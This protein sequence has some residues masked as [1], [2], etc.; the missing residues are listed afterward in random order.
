MAEDAPDWI[1]PHV[2]PPYVGGAAICE[3]VSDG[4]N[5]RL[6]DLTGIHTETVIAMARGQ[7]KTQLAIEGGTLYLWFRFYTIG[8]PGEYD[9]EV[10]F[11]APS[12]RCI[13]RGS[14]RCP[15]NDDGYMVSISIV[16]FETDESGLHVFEIGLDQRLATRIPFRIDLLQTGI[17]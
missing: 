4:D 10:R 3:T 13:E 8:A 15:F 5:S 16:R 12:G 1:G 9:V 7:T 2:G 17:G 6:I 14:M 11:L